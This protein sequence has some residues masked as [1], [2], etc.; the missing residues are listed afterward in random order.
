MRAVRWL[1]LV[2]AIALPGPVS[3]PGDAGDESGCSASCR[4]LCDPRYKEPTS[5]HCYFWTSP[6][7][8]LVGETCPPGSHVV[9]FGSLEELQF[10]TGAAKTSDAG[11]IRAWCAL[12]E[13]GVNDAGT[14]TFTTSLAGWRCS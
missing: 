7:T 3:D 8:T 14:T 4:V 10:V 13:R 11:N 2:A 12:N 6:A 5:N 9:T 1:G